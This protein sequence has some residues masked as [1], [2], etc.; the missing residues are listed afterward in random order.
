MKALCFPG[1][2]GSRHL[3][4]YMPKRYGPK[5]TFF[6]SWNEENRETKLYFGQGSKARKKALVNLTKGGASACQPSAAVRLE[7]V[8][9]S[10]NNPRLP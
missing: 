2:S 6:V 4:F 7:S 8:S 10:R 5:R 1:F 9:L 3:A